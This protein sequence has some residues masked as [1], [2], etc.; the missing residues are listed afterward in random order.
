MFLKL[1]C[2][3]IEMS[4]KNKKIVEVEKEDEQE[5]EY[6]F[7]KIKEVEI[8]REREMDKKIEELS[9]GK[10]WKDMSEEE[11]EKVS[12]YI[13]CERQKQFDVEYDN[14][15]MRCLRYLRKRHFARV[16]EAIAE[17]FIAIKKYRSCYDTICWLLEL[18]LPRVDTQTLITI[19]HGMQYIS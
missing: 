15:Q 13:E 6:W 18:V 10:E 7:E 19:K 2:D 1:S 14:Y 12:D 11:K 4:L 17:K 3:R 16:C 8:E 5:D 9:G